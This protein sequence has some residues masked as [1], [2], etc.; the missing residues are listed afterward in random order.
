MLIRQSLY[1][2]YDVCDK[3]EDELMHCMKELLKVLMSL[4][5]CFSAALLYVSKVCYVT[6]SSYH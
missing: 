4:A 2:L 3:N 5:L 1:F 6:R